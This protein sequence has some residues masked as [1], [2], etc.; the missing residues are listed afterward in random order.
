MFSSIIPFNI[1]LLDSMCRVQNSCHHLCF[2]LAPLLIRFPKMICFTQILY[3]MN[4]RSSLIFLLCYYW[5]LDLKWLHLSETALSIKS[6]DSKSKTRVF[7]P[8]W[9]TEGLSRPW[10]RDDGKLWSHS[11]VLVSKLLSDKSQNLRCK[12]ICDL[13]DLNC[14]SFVWV[15]CIFWGSLS[16]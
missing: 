16:K 8:T 4:S 2:P 7:Q 12:W 9:E 10:R 5:C 3:W 11:G 1:S 15:V 6:L 14:S 13:Y